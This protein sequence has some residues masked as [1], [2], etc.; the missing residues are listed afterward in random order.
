MPK[1]AGPHGEVLGWLSR[2]KAWAT[3]FIRVFSETM[4]EAGLVSTGLECLNNFSRLWTI[5]VA[6]SCPVPGPG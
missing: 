5:Q 2:K 4:D 1:H 6:P 3:A